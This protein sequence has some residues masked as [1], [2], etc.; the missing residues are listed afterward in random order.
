[1]FVTK[2][3]HP[4]V[5]ASGEICVNTLKRDWS[6]ALG[7]KHILLTIKCLLIVPNP[8]SALNDEAGKMLSDRY[9][10]YCQRAASWTAIHASSKKERD[11]YS[12]HR[13]SL[14]AATASTASTASTTA[15]TAADTEILVDAA[16]ADAARS[17]STL[18]I[19]GAPTNDSANADAS[20]QLAADGGADADNEDEDGEGAIDK[21]NNKSNEPIAAA[22]LAAQS[23]VP[24]AKKPKS[25]ASVAKPTAA[26]AAKKKLNRRL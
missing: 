6:P 7:I 23:D 16:A 2:I 25:A 9:E 5:S 4:N 18:A 8:D 13:A 21:E 1:V 22:R 19:D 26:A 10:D 17:A 20:S 12:Q 15:S 14:A 24:A 11:V 3:F